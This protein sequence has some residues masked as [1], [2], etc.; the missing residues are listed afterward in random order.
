MML[1]LSSPN[2]GKETK[3]ILFLLDHFPFRGRLI[4]LP[5][6]TSMFNSSVTLPLKEFNFCDQTPSIRNG[7]QTK[8]RILD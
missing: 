6:N 5:S 7:V 2:P 4:R 1:G 3:T 8:R